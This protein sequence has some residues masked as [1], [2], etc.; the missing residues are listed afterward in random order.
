LLRLLYQRI[1]DKNGEALGEMLS[2]LADPDARPALI[3]CA[4]GKDRTGVIVALLLALLGVPDETIVADYTL[5]N[6]HYAAFYEKMGGALRRAWWVGI[7]PVRLRPLL[8]ADPA[9]MADTL[10]YLRQQYGS[11]EAYSQEMAGLPAD[12]LHRLRQE[13]LV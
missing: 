3:H 6:A 2:R 9:L 1:L 12:T 8:L 4:I 5:S 7:S 11:A 13:L 10:A